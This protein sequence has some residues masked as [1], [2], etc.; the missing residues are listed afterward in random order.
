PSDFGYNGARPTHP[1]LLDWLAGE[2]M[3]S[4]GCQ[5]P[6]VASGVVDPRRAWR[7]KPL[8]RMILLSA[9]YRQDGRMSDRAMSVDRNNHLLW[10]RTPRRLEAE[11][12][13]DSI[14]AASGKLDRRMGGPGYNLWEKNTNYVTV[15]RPKAELGPEEFRRMVYQFK[16]RTQQDPTFGVFDCP[17]AALARPR[18]ESSTTVLQ[19]LNLLNGRLIVQQ[20]DYFAERL[21]REAGDDPE[22]QVELA[23]R[24]AFG[25]PPTGR[26]RSAA[27][28]LVR[29]HGTAALCRA[30][31]NANEFVY[32][33]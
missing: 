13:R 7:L 2:F 10:R 9:T 25:R 23:F 14:L 32:V 29:Q 27:A 30:V 31:Y 8:H 17:D 18:R 15:F 19:A 24:L 12:I 20:A 26:E 11:A 4:G 5:P 16:P 22:R 1:E 33:D 28:A 6:D 21:R 3:A